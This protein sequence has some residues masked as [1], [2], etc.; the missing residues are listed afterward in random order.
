[1]EQVETQQTTTRRVAVGQPQTSGGYQKK[2][3]IF[4]TYQIIWYILGVV[5]VL[6][7]FRI[8]F[9]ALAAN[10]TGFVRFIYDISDPLALPFA[11]IFRLTVSKSNIIEWS[12]LIAMIVYPIIAYGV[13]KLIQLVKPTSPQEVEQGTSNP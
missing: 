10:P 12:T 11:G 4:K 1:M 2:K 5:E 13:V 7:A 3:V 9:K 6:L 8:F